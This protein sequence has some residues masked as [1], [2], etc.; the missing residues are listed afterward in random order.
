MVK[1]PVEER[2]HAVGEIVLLE[3]L[4]ALDLVLKERVQVQDRGTAVCFVNRGAGLAG[5]FEGH[6][7]VKLKEVKMPAT[8]LLEFRKRLRQQFWPASVSSRAGNRRPGRDSNHPKR[9]IRHDACLIFCLYRA[10]SLRS[11]SQVREYERG[12]GATGS[13]ANPL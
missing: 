12:I 9:N 13:T 1:R 7:D 3:K 10:T 4:R 6:D 8:R 5:C 11:R 2:L